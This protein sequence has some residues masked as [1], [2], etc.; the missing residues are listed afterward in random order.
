MTVWV[1]FD[2][3]TSREIIESL[4]YKISSFL[5]LLLLRFASLKKLNFNF[6]GLDASFFQHFGIQ[7]G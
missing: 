3:M 1:T 6:T 2:N 7:L 5:K 4:A